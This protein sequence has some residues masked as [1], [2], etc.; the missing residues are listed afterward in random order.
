M[1]KD[2]FFDT[3][4]NLV[5]EKKISCVY[6]YLLVSDSLHNLFLHFRKKRLKMLKNVFSKN[7][8]ELL[9]QINSSYRLLNFKNRLLLFRRPG[10]QSQATRARAVDIGEV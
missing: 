4:M 10:R 7:V 2:E 9:P 5:H 6:R 8:L 3:H 1:L